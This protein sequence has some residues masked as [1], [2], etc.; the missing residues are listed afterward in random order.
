MDKILLIVPF[1]YLDQTLNEDRRAVLNL[2]K[3]SLM[4]ISRACLD[5]Y[6]ANVYQTGTS[7]VTPDPLLLYHFINTSQLVGFD[8]H[9]MEC[10][11]NV[12]MSNRVPPQWFRRTI[13]DIA[14]GI[15]CEIHPKLTL[16]IEM[17]RYHI[18]TVTYQIFECTEKSIHMELRN[19]TTIHP[20]VYPFAL[21][22]PR[23]V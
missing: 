23:T 20:R 17:S 3:V 7:L 16:Q 1:H 12:P 15:Y 5:F 6:F 18:S 13:A 2:Y 4:D 21:Y 8:Q 22:A 14:Y 9:L 11:M 10:E 19:E